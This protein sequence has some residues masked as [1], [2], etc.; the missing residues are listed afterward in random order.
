VSNKPPLPCATYSGSAFRCHIAD[1]D[2][3]TKQTTCHKGWTTTTGDKGRPSHHEGGL[4]LAWVNPYGINVESME[5]IRNSMWNPWNQCWLKPQPICCSMD[6]M[7]SMWNDHGMDMEWLIPQEFGHIHLGFHGQ[8]HMDS[9]EQFHMD[10]VEIPWNK[11]P[12]PWETPLSK[13]M[14]PLRIEHLPPRA[15]HVGTPMMILQL[16][17]TAF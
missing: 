7:D 2:M 16:H 9:M 13:I 6:I 1:S 5:S 3:A 14:S 11:A 10:S 12:F 8:V 17:H 4:Y 15:D